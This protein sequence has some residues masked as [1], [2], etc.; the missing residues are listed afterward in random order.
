MC[1]VVTS[2]HWS[3]HARSASITP[4]R[5]APASP[6]DRCSKGPA[7]S[8]SP[9]PGSEPVSHSK[10]TTFRGRGIARHEVDA[11]E[12]DVE[13]LERVVAQ[14]LVDVSRRF[15]VD[16]SL[17][18]GIALGPVMAGVIGTR[19]FTYDV[20]GDAV[21][22]ASRMESGGIPDTVQ[23][24]RSVYEQLG[25]TISRSC[26]FAAFRAPLN[27]AVRLEPIDHP[28]GAR[29]LH[30]HHVGEFGL[31]GAGV[32]VQSRENQPLCA[33]DAQASDTTIASSFS[34]G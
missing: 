19:K 8:A 25:F 18:I 1:S 6:V 14:L 5:S 20:W 12:R 15:G 11:L 9:I 33:R 3:P 21:N 34:S 4:A 29:A 30:L 13:D 7:R 28:P 24:T 16:L 26:E 32:A 2:S 31:R 27:P 10:R 22:L 17:R 23:V